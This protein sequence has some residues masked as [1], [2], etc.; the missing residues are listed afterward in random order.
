MYGGEMVSLDDALTTIQHFMMGKGKSS[1]LTPLL[2]MYFVLNHNKTVYIVVP[3][4][5]KKQTLKTM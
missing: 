5:L 1:V 2:T 3:E 4:H